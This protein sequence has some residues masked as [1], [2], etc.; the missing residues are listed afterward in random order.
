MEK[1]L[2]RPVRAIGLMSGT[3]M[4]GID[5][6][7]VTTD[8]VTVSSTGLS[9]TLEYD[10]A[11]RERLREALG[12]R[13]RNESVDSVE[14]ELTLA[15]AEAVDRLL[16]RA[17]L[18]ASQIG[19][20]GFHGHTITH[21]PE[22]GLTWQIG[23]AALLAAET[24]ID[25][26]YD[27]RGA[28]LAGGGEGAPLAPVYH[29]ALS[30]DLSRP[31][32][33]LNIGGVANVTWIGE[34]DSLLAFDTGPGN[35]LIDDWVRRH[36]GAR[37]DVDGSL[38]R[39]GRVDEGIVASLLEHRYFVQP[40]PKSLDRNAFDVGILSEFACSDG[41]ATL[42]AFTAASVAR[43]A[44]FFGGAPSRWLITGGGRLNPA[45]MA[46]LSRRLTAPVHPVEDVGWDGDSL[47]AQAF[48]FMAVR[49]L[50]G[51][52]ISFPATTGTA[53]P[54][55]GGRLEKSHG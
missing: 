5:A 9:L 53:A 43:A 47:E 38:A 1:G 8:G 55:P 24:G 21:A 36:T 46:E 20:I 37:A 26:V 17:G 11:V 49:M 54:T 6:A 39:Q 42:T 41:A 2:E 16:A 33:V 28:D 7:L 13:E 34:D 25:V 23:D 31:L 15:H 51:L 35:A 32:A 14:R 22:E 4:D 52:P 12:C 48:A 30:R 3:S 44:G 45:L 18:S 19:V 40:P 27:F 29:R 50:A 10:T